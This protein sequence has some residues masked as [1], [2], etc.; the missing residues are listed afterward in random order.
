MTHGD[1]RLDFIVAY[2]DERPPERDRLGAHR[3]AAEIGV[4]IDAGEELPRTRTQG[5]A[6]FLPI[7]SIPQLDR[8]GRRGNQLDPTFQ[9]WRGASLRQLLQPQAD[10]GL[11]LGC[12]SGVASRGGDG[13]GGLRLRVT[14]ID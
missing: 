2:F 14:E 3:H 12:V 1:D 11:H 5:R 6:D 13:G 7:I 8:R 4:E 10:E 9:V